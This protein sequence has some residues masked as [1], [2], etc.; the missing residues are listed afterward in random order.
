MLLRESIGRSG[1]EKK[2]EIV[3]RMVIRM[4]REHVRSSILTD[5]GLKMD[6]L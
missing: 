5:K 1:V 6:S 4:P 3:Y 2:V